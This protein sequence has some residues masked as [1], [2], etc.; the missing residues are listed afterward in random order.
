[1]FGMGGRDFCQPK[2]VTRGQARAVV[3]K[4]IEARPQRMHEDF[5]MLAV[6]ALKAAWPCQL[7]I[8][9]PKR[10]RTEDK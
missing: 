7:P 5:G 3:I 6:E 8:P 1:V 2:G 9:V 10:P 4:Y